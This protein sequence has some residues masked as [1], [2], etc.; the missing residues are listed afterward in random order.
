MLENLHSTARELAAA[1]ESRPRRVQFDAVGVPDTILDARAALSVGLRVREGY[2]A[3]AGEGTPTIDDVAEC[4]FEMPVSDV[5]ATL[6]GL[7]LEIA[8]LAS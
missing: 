1:G 3:V 4:L 2:D 6:R 5:R 7:G 8:G